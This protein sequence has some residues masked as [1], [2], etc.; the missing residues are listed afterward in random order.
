[1]RARG[2]SV[3]APVCTR[4]SSFSVSCRSALMVSLRREVGTHRVEPGARDDE[5]PSEEHVSEVLAGPDAARAPDLE[6]VA[7]VVDVEEV[8]PRVIQLRALLL[9]VEGTGHRA[10]RP[11]VS[12]RKN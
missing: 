2:S 9:V 11:H 7:D 12:V 8:L 1:M 3:P 10:A 4:M 5:V 6:P